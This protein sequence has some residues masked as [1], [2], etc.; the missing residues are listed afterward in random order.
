[1]PLQPEAEEAASLFA[2]WFDPI[3]AALR[4][5]VRAF[6]E[7][8]IS[9][10]LDAALARPRY[11]RRP[12]SQGGEDVAAE[13]V[14][15]R[16]GRRTR[17]LTGTFGATEVTVPRARIACRGRQD[18]RVEEQGAQGLPAAHEDRRRADC[19]DLPGRHQ[20]APGTPRACGALRWGGRQGRRQ[21]HLAQDQE[22]L[23]RLE[24][25]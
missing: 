25:S 3:E 23:G 7:T 20:H 16:H 9:S 17:T 22:R 2:D 8:M 21:P 24:R 13:V 18:G 14:G 1:M 5:R 10:E 12:A 4:D 15:H 19:R 6:I 11:A